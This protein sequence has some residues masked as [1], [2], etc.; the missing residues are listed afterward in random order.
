MTTTTT[1]GTKNT[2]RDKRTDVLLKNPLTELCLFGGLD[3][4]DK[5]E[6]GPLDTHDNPSSPYHDKRLMLPLVP[7]MVDSVTLRGVMVPI[8]VT[9]VCID[10]VDRLVVLEGRQ[11]VRWAR[12]ANVRRAAQGLP[13]ILVKCDV[14]RAAASD[15]LLAMSIMVTGNEVRQDTDIT[16]KIENAKRLMAHGADVHYL[17]THFGKPVGVIESWLRFDD[18]AITDVKRAVEAG[19]LALSAGMSIARLKDPAAQRQA[20]SEVTLPS[21]K[22][23][24]TRKAREVAKRIESPDAH[25]GVSDKRTQRALLKLVEAKDHKGA[26]KE[27]LAWWSGVEAAL[28]LIVGGDEKPDEKLLALLGQARV[29]SEV[30]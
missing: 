26:N 10:G 14:S 27:A 6:H 28:R 30:K 3:L 29:S 2:N 11:R 22:P 21:G 25:I 23:V 18:T 16:M 12:I 17:A 4:L 9:R 20:L 15:P 24:S 8:I 1:N 13:E 19:Q 5:S 7:E